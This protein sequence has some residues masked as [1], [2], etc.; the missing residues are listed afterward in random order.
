MV[1]DFKPSYNVYR[2]LF[3][4]KKNNSVSVSSHRVNNRCFPAK[5]Q[6]SN[7]TTFPKNKEGYIVSLRLN[8]VG[9]LNIAGPKPSDP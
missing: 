9:D 4:T 8:P 3:E 6:L 2:L 1:I 5:G 7:E